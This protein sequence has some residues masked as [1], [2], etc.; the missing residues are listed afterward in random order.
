LI[1]L[2]VG[3]YAVPLGCPS[4]FIN[5]NPHLGALL[6]QKS[7]SLDY[8]LPNGIAIA[9]GNPRIKNLNIL[10]QFLVGLIDRFGGKYIVQH[11]KSLICLS[12]LWTNIIEEDEITA[13]N[14]DFFPQKT[15][16][17]MLS[18]FS[19]NSAT[20]ISVPQ[21]FM[22]ISKYSMCLGTR[23]HGVQAAIQSGVPAVCLYIDSRTKELCETMQIP[24]ISAHDFQRQ[25]DIEH[26]INTLKKWNWE[27]Y[28]RNRLRLA[29]ETET[30]LEQNG[31]KGKRKQIL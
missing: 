22:D 18:W 27:S 3:D 16:E 6:A 9:A 14:N 29:K 13:I 7:E 11:P 17:E 30:F 26:V 5:R 20:Y 1:E 12:Q 19:K 23:I 25:P 8:G 15:R 10:E 4:H 21:W 24:K 31:L 2:G 28:E